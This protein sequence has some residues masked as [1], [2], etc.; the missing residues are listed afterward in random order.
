MVFV[1]K[2]QRVLSHLQD[3]LDALDAEAEV[4]CRDALTYLQGP[5]R[6]F[7]IVFLD[8]PYQDKLLAPAM[9]ALEANGWLGKDAF[10]YA[11]NPAREP[12]P[13]IPR[14]WV[15]WRQSKAGQVGYYLFRRQRSQD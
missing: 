2:N 1:E 12:L 4:V 7:D 14:G 9:Q 11:E 8:P 5:A 13:D 15:L 10:V 6:K 3:Q